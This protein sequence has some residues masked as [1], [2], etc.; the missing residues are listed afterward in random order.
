MYEHGRVCSVRVKYLD[1]MF[2]RLMAFRGSQLQGKIFEA[3]TLPRDMT[4][5]ICR[6]YCK[7]QIDP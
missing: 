2:S 4:G 3:K 6:H 5:Y 7:S 1:D